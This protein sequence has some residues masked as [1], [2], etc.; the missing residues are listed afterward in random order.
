MN[1]CDWKEEDII[2]NLLSRHAASLTSVSLGECVLTDRFLAKVKE[3]LSDKI[4][5]LVLRALSG[6]LLLKFF[7]ELLSSCPCLKHLAIARERADG[8]LWPTTGVKLS[9]QTFVDVLHSRFQYDLRAISIKSCLF[10]L[11]P[12]FKLRELFKTSPHLTT[13]YVGGDCE[14]EHSS[15]VRNNPQL[16][17]I[18]F[19]ENCFHGCSYATTKAKIHDDAMF[20]GLAVLTNLIELELCLSRINTEAL[21]MV[22]LS[23][24]NLEVFV[25][26]CERIKQWAPNKVKALRLAEKRD[27]EMQKMLAESKRDREE[28]AA[29]MARKKAVGTQTKQRVFKS[30]AAISIL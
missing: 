11:L 26:R 25:L 13:I 14:V 4:E 1:V 30:A 8:A 18:W 27:A 5:E 24:L 12:F 6:S 21:K 2:E 7:L 16:E 29:D 19:S 10:G 22:L 28:W 3:H 15:Q 17:I 9:K 23:S 20:E